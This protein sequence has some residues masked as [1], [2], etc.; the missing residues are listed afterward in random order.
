MGAS[1]AV[2]AVQYQQFKQLAFDV[3]FGK[4]IPMKTEI[5]TRATYDSDGAQESASN[6]FALQFFEDTTSIVE[7][8]SQ[9][10]KIQAGI[11]LSTE[12]L[13]AGHAISFVV[14]QQSSTHT[15]TEINEVLEKMMTHV[16][17]LKNATEVI[18][19][20]PVGYLL[21]SDPGWI[22]SNDGA[23]GAGASLASRSRLQKMEIGDDFED[24]L[25]IAPGA[26]LKATLVG[27]PTSWTT[28]DDVTV[29][30]HIHA[31]KAV[32]GPNSV[33]TGAILGLSDAR[34]R[35]EE[36]QAA[37]YFTPRG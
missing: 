22:L 33:K 11:A 24:P 31:W 1:L 25:I 20:R 26:S 2:K 15:A 7:R 3:G 16:L 28:T 5:R 35:K 17:Q 6:E 30:V 4:Q 12:F 18:Y 29:E 37:G 23:N 34:A 19:E 8:K 27:G 10:P 21:A 13:H 9:D 36:L 14:H 32:R